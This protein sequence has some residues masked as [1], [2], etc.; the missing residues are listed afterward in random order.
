MDLTFLVLAT[1]ILAVLAALGGLWV[2]SRCWGASESA[3][4]RLLLSGL[5]I[6][7]LALLVL[8]NEPFFSLLHRRAHSTLPNLLRTVLGGLYFVF[9]ILVVTLAA[10]LIYRALRPAPPSPAGADQPPGSASAAPARWSRLQPILLLAMAFSL[11]GGL[12]CALHWA[13]IWDHTSDGLYGLFLTL[14]GSLAALGAGFLMTFL[15]S[16]WRRLAGVLFLVLTPALLFLTFNRGWQVSY[17][18][19]TEQRA[20]A[21]AA[22]LERYHARAGVYPASLGD[23]APGE[24][25]YVLPPVILQ[26]EPWCYQA[27]GDSYRLGAVHRKFF[28][29]PLSIRMYASS[30]Q[31]PDSAWECQARLEELQAIYDAHL[32][33]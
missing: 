1:L 23:L 28:S 31:A 14:A 26:G 16:G 10:A 2:I 20:A 22:A 12:L 29:M 7:A 27:T 15:L 24:L 11:L 9:P 18:A 3:S 17:Q 8:F 13:A 21:I 5:W 30:G 32:T 25:L 19:I 4:R 6:A 33:P